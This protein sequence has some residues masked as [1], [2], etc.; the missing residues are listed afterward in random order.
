MLFRSD[1]MGGFVAGSVVDE[2]VTVSVEQNVVES[3]FLVSRDNVPSTATLELETDCRKLQC[4]VVNGL[5][6][7]IDLA[8]SLDRFGLQFSHGLTIAPCTV[9]A[10]EKEKKIEA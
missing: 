3:E 2:I 6:L 1:Q 4:D 5:G 8:D 10:R 7:F 9:R